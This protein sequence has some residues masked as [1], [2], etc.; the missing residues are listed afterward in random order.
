MMK[1][2]YP[3]ELVAFFLKAFDHIHWGDERT[4]MEWDYADTSRRFFDQPPLAFDLTPSAAMVREV[5]RIKNSYIPPYQRIRQIELLTTASRDREGRWQDI[6]PYYL[7]AFYT[8][9]TFMTPEAFI[10]YIPAIINR[11]YDGNLDVERSMALDYM[12]SRLAREAGD[13]HFN[14]LL[15]KD[16]LTALLTFLDII[17]KDGSDPQFE[18]IVTAL[19]FFYPQKPLYDH[20]MDAIYGKE[21]GEAKAIAQEMKRQGVI[22]L[23]DTSSNSSDSPLEEYIAWDK[24]EAVEILLRHGATLNYESLGDTAVE[25]LIETA[26]NRSISE[27]IRYLDLFAQYGI[28]WELRGMNSW[29]SLIPY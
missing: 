18:K 1:K 19:G 13:S 3:P 8:G 25:T 20:F 15:S 14:M 28:N 21:F 10:F 16:M 24:F 2:N 11:V 7:E 17:D 22:D 12:L 5:E 27:T 4:L 29:P 26:E 6:Q 9:I 23:G